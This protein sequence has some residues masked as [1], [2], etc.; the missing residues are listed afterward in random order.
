MQSTRRES[1]GQAGTRIC[2]WTYLVVKMVAQFGPPEV[3]TFP[4]SRNG[5]FPIGFASEGR[6]PLELNCVFEYESPKTKKWLVGSGRR[7]GLLTVGSRGVR[8]I[9]RQMSRTTIATLSVK[10]AADASVSHSLWAMEQPLQ[11]RLPT[12]WMAQELLDTPPACRLVV[13]VIIIEL[14]VP[15][16]LHRQ[17]CWAAL[18]FEVILL[19]VFVVCVV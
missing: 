5:G 12:Q 11:T 8:W 17:W 13:V 9:Q 6:A 7:S 10:M 1:G 3:V 2:E 19:I 4:I 15:P 14:D 18:L 16:P